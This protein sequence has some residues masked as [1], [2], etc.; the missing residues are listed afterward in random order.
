VTPCSSILGW[1]LAIRK[2]FFASSRNFAASLLDT[3][4][5][6]IARVNTLYLKTYKTQ[7]HQARL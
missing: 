6:G 3:F 1:V 7:V 4:M 5:E 2:S